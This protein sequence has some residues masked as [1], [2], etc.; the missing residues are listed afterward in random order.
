MSEFPRQKPELEIIASDEG[1]VV[2]DPARER[3]HYLNQTGAM[4]LSLCNGQQSRC[5]RCEDV[6]SSPQTILLP[7]THHVVYDGSTT[8]QKPSGGSREKILI[9][10]GSRINLGSVA[11][12]ATA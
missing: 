8:L 10:I 11:V 2:R 1:F 6:H 9:I 3:V 7:G 12:T 5:K 4:V